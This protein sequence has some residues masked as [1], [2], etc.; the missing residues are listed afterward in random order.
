MMFNLTKLPRS[1]AAPMQWGN[2]SSERRE[3]GLS[4]FGNFSYTVFPD[5]SEEHGEGSTF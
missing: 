5:E 4:F 3:D 1:H 2:G